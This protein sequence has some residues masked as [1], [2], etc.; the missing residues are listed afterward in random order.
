LFFINA[1]ILIKFMLIFNDIVN[2]NVAVYD[3]LTYIHKYIQFLMHQILNI[4]ISDISNF[5]FVIFCFRSMF[6]LIRIIFKYLFLSFLIILSWVIH[7]S[8]IGIRFVRLFILFRL[9]FTFLFIFFAF[10][11]LGMFGI[12]G[13]GW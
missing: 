3:M 11:A 1:I 10:I 6:I 4:S 2:F 13:L 7:F 12:M 9:C 5:I 8:I